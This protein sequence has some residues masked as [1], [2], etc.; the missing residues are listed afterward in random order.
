MKKVE[1]SVLLFLVFVLVLATG[2]TYLALNQ[3]SKSKDNKDDQKLTV[4]LVNEDQGA[5]FNGDDYQF[6]NEFIKAIEKDNQHDWYVVSRGVAENGLE[7]NVY[8]MMIVIPND[9]TKKALSIDSQAPEQVVVN[10]KINATDNSNLKAKAEKTASS[11]LGEFNRR[12]IDVYFASVLGNLHEAQDNIGTLVNKEQ[13]Y[14]NVYNNSIHRPLAGYTS[15][16][17]A[18]Q[19]N[20]K[21]SRDSFQGLQGILKDFEGTLGQ[22]VQTGNTY[23]DVF[24]DFTSLQAAN[25]LASKGFSDQLINLDSKMNDGN[26]LQQLESLVEANKA[27]NEQFHLTED[28]SANIL[29]E[30]A[31]LQTYLTSTKE[32]IENVE[33]ELA[34]KLA[35]DMQDQVREQLKNEIKN[36]S[37]GEQN[38]YLNQFFAQPDENA[39]SAIQ[40]QIDQL[41]SLNPE[42]LNGLALKDQTITQLKNVMEFTNKYNR[43]FN[44]SP[45]SKTGDIPLTTQVEQVQNSLM[46]NGVTL[47]DTVSLPENKK[48]GQEFTLSIPEEFSVSQVLLTLPNGGEMDYTHPFVQKQKIDL[49]K[50]DAGVFTVKLQVKLKAGTKVDVFQPITW[51]WTLDQKDVTAV[52][53][54]ETPE[55][56]EPTETTETPEI[57]EPTETTETPE[58]PE[59]TETTETPK[60]TE[61]TETP[62]T[63]ETTET[64]KTLDHNLDAAEQPAVKVET[65]NALAATAS[66]NSIPQSD[67]SNTANN[68]GSDKKEPE[69]Q[70]STDSQDDSNTNKNPKKTLNIVNNLV[71]H[72]VMS[73]LLQDSTNVLV[74]AASDTVSDYQKMLSMYNLY[75][76]IGLDQFNRS[77]FIDQLNQ[78]SLTD[79]ASEGSLYYLFNKQD[80]VDILAN[81]VAGQTTEEIKQQTEQL[82]SEMDTYLTLVNDADNH[83]MRMAE[84]INQTSAQAESQNT[85]L[86]KTLEDLALW[87]EESSNLNEEQ[88][89]ILVDGDEEQSAVLT[90]D[91][92]LKTLLAESQLL[93]D[94]SKNNLNSADHVY[95]TFDAIDQ[96]AKEIQASGTTLVK[97]ADDLSDNLTDKVLQDQNFAANFAG[98]LANSRIGERQNENLLSF[99]SNPVQ[100]KSAGVIMAAEDTFSP[101][102]MVLICFIVGLFT[103]YV[104]S[105]NERKRLNHDSFAEEQTLVKQNTP[106]TI[107]TACVGLIEGLVI[108]LLSGYLLKINEEKFILWVGMMVLIIVTMVLAA[109]YLLRQLKMAGMFVLLVILS[110]YLFLTES[111]GL[112]LNPSSLAAKLRD[113]SPLQYIE[114]LLIKFGSGAGENNTILF[115]LIAITV[116]S[117]AGHLFVIHRLS[118][119]EEVV[120]EGISE[121]L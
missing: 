114:T 83:S 43:E 15:Q 117:L 27:I 16:F 93:A 66:E 40:K 58:T 119:N 51:K 98:V 74:N 80:I 53:I 72:Q 2:S 44:Y 86:G 104:L 105:N 112:Q 26:V 67:Q 111:I 36:S 95:Q 41:P 63:P 18:V 46:N 59:P 91:G 121:N 76:G 37:D 9:F 17:G 70:G 88:S 29:S 97:E 32:K 49:P 73:P 19:T 21:L 10:Y 109:T 78:S 3:T 82:K 20:T 71:T 115:S 94:Q 8:N 35:S 52:D 45:A 13:W 12:I 87:R 30:S 116:I 25:L 79:M 39:K 113:Y 75:F 34:E 103:A 14:S 64:P 118:K 23:K 4:A 33:T 48:G 96:Q 68:P 54:P 107:I 90:L 69:N 85:S 110:L 102:F 61:T 108:G 47:S 106:I 24:T 1:R 77:D 60:T 5:E 81:Y 62:K 92:Q 120:H 42:D 55:I 100:T 101:Y 28:Q 7:R 99:L 6:G 50:T 57:P 65:M 89:N 38:V 11:I 84:M 31:A 56:P 22:G